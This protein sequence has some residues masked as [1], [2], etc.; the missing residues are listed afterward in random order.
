M[1]ISIE[2]LYELFGIFSS[3]L[4]ASYVLFIKVK[5]RSANLYIGIFILIFGLS[6]LDKFISDAG[7]Y[8]NYPDFWLIL[9]ATYFLC[10]PAL[11]F[12]IR[13]IAFKKTKLKKIDIIH[14]IPFLFINVVTIILFHSKDSSTK[15]HIANTLEGLNEWFLP[16]DYVLL[17]IMS[18]VYLIL[19]I[20]VVI[21]FRK[22]VL[23][24]YSNLEK[25]N[26]KW[27][28]Q[29]TFV[30]VYYIVAAL[31]DNIIRFFVDE[32]LSIKLVYILSPV[33]VLF[34]LWIM[35]KVIS[36]PY[37]FNGVDANAKLLKELLDEPSKPHKN[38]VENTSSIRFAADQ[39]QLK[40]K[41]ENHMRKEEPFLDPSLTIYDLSKQIGTSIKELSLLINH[42][43][44]QHFFD[45]VNGFRIR[46]AME[47]FKN[48]ND[49]KLTV[50]EVLYEVG[51]NSKSSFNTAFKKFTGTTPSEFKRKAS[52]SAA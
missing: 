16:V 3:F 42:D 20:Q 18:I 13:S 1:E 5:E 19:S 38:D 29:L 2:K 49:D 12:Y 4:F 11:Y 15:L 37:L 50:L 6:F 8:D 7:F 32:S 46:K 45:Y 9:P 31:V 10:Y 30:F 17:R 33:D 28:L 41:L 35:Y 21:R 44:N 43:L 14:L 26:Y 47:I 40:E 36:Q 25:R 52:S 34:L 48:T 23:E 39:N 24:S 51:F 27:I 22:I